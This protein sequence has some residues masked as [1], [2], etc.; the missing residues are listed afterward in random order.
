MKLLDTLRD[1][2][3]ELAG[4]AIAEIIDRLYIGETLRH[5]NSEGPGC[6]HDGVHFAAFR[7]LL[8]LPAWRIFLA[9]WAL[10]TRSIDD[11]IEDILTDYGKET[12]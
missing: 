8:R 6:P 7:T 3:D 11:R 9:W 10:G 2:Y 1:R 5:L 4:E 12:R